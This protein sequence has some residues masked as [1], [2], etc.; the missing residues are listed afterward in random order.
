MLKQMMAKEIE[1]LEDIK[2]IKGL[3]PEDILLLVRYENGHIHGFYPDTDTSE[4]MIQTA[5]KTLNIKEPKNIIQKAVETL[6]IKEPFEKVDVIELPDRIV[7]HNR[8]AI[9]DILMMTCAIRDFKKAFPSIKIR[10]ESTAG[11]LWDNNDNVDYGEPWIDVID[12]RKGIEKKITGE[13]LQKLTLSAKY[14][15]IDGK[16][17]LKVYIGS[18]EGT[19]ASNRSDLHF[20]NAY[21][22]SIQKALGITFEQGPIRP[23]VYMT[24]EEYDEPPLIESPYWIITAGEKGDWTA[25]TYPPEWWQEVVNKLPNIKFVQI[26]VKGH[27]HKLLEG[28]NVVNFIGETQGR[29]DGIRRLFNLFNNCQG[30][31]GLVSFH[32]HLAAAFGKP[33]VVVAGAR[34]PVHFTRYPGHQYLSMDGCLPCTIGTNDSPKACWYCNVNRCDFMTNIAGKI[35]PGCIHKITSDEIV[36]GIQKYYKGGRLDYETPHGKSALINIVQLSKVVPIMVKKNEILLPEIAKGTG[37][38]FG[39]SSITDRDWEF[40]KTIIQKYNVK[41]VLEFGAGLSTLLFKDLGMDLTTYETDVCFMAPLIKA[42]SQNIKMWDGREIKDPL[43]KF[44]LI[45]VDGPSGGGNREFSTKIAA[46]YGELV[47]VH[48]AGRKWEKEWQEKYL[49][50][51]FEMVA[52]GGHRCHFWKRKIKVG[53]IKLDPLTKKNYPSD[54]FKK[55]KSDVIRIVFNGRG[56]G[57]AERS[58]TWL[59]NQLAHTEKTIEYVSPTHI[60]GTFKKEG[61]N[62]IHCYSNERLDDIKARIQAPCD[63]LILYANDWVWDFKKENIQDWF[64]NINARRKIMIVNYR[65]GDIGYAKWT[66]DFDTYIFLNFYLQGEFLSRRHLNGPDKSNFETLILPSPTDLTDFFKASKKIDYSGNLR[67]VRHSSQGNVKY[68]PDFDNKVWQILDRIPNSE[69]HLMPGPSSLIETQHNWSGDYGNKLHLY[70]KNEVSI[71]EFLSKGNCFWYHL[72]NNY[73]DQG[74]K[75]IMEAQAMGLPVVTVDH[76]GPLDRVVPGTGFT[77]NNFTKQLEALEILDIEIQRE[78]MGQVAKIHAAAN[79]NPK[80]WI[81][82]ILS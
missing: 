30:S 74:P 37:F 69:I 7:F 73:Q 29:E 1:S 78:K 58:V 82:E 31:I 44:D 45:F 54:A 11:H 80:K 63:T 47:V 46:E 79:Y 76:S 34:E 17:A 77:C 15:A 4:N 39:G 12:P 42:G 9:G 56:E 3:E 62:K 19:N 35:I 23:D 48:D 6:N 8:Q 57:G 67:I 21:R 27:P 50:N 64:S 72:P 53:G 59:L 13:L 2:E 71:P 18:G 65:M 38:T 81:Q 24:N 25:K 40:L 41:T 26:G 51:D 60:C 16:K 36:R 43:S 68:S 66:Y 10:V 52:K 5:M 55:T 32:M 33:C 20:A 70:N 22:L 49:K 14:T 28:K 61:R 75:V